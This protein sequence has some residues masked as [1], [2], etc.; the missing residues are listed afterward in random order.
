MALEDLG[1]TDKVSFYTQPPKSPDLNI[2]D[3]GLFNALQAR[4]Y[5]LA[6][7]NGVE[8]IT[9]AEERYEEYPP[10]KINRLFLTLQTIF[11]SI[12]ENNGD[13]QF[14]IVQMLG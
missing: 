2:L 14:K 6:T 12:L 7:K 5:D 3:L 8:L 4:Y 1:L 10:S 11:N 9:M 13:N